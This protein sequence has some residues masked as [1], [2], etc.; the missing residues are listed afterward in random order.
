MPLFETLAKKGFRVISFDLP[1]HGESCGLLN[2]IDL[3]SF[4]D[5]LK[6][7]VAVENDTRVGAYDRPLVL[8]GWSTGGLLAIRA[9]QTESFKHRFL[10]GVVLLAPAVSVPALVGVKGVVTESTLTSNPNPPHYGKPSPASPLLKPVFASQLLLNTAIADLGYFD[11]SIPLL[12]II[13]GEEED[14]Y[15]KTQKVKQWATKLKSQSAAMRVN[16]QCP[17]AFHELDN[18]PGSIGEMVRKA[19]LDFTFEVSNRFNSYNPI[20]RPGCEVF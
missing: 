5:L 20:L 6:F 10:Q 15:V 4:S 17:H 3:Y 9:V 2:N 14:K 16:I 19:V 8:A 1:S 18:E 12:T 7:A 11:T 13:A